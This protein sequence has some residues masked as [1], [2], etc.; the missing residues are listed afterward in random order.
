[1]RLKY[2]EKW[3]IWRKGKLAFYTVIRLYIRQ[4]KWKKVTKNFKI[5]YTFYLA[6]V[7][8]GIYFKKKL[9]V[10]IKE[11]CANMFIKILFMIIKICLETG[12]L[13]YG[14]SMQ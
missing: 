3:K 7:F 4:R 8:L 10:S 6:N 13:N 14:M 11:L 1:M 9:K 12:W 2:R 5:V